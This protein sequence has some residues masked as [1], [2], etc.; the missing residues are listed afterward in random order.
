MFVDSTGPFIGN[1]DGKYFGLD[2]SEPLYIGG[3]PNT[4]EIS[5]EIA[6]YSGFVGCISRFKVDFAHKDITK[7]TLAKH[8]I[9]SCETCSEN[10]CNNEGV[11][12]ESLSP[13]GYYCICPAGYSG[14]TCNKLKGEACSS[15]KYWF[16]LFLNFLDNRS[17]RCLWNWTMC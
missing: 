2:L 15:C 1:A 8:G 11:C 9:T 13:E 5:P 14:A 16:L 12:Q 7:H 3:V 4:N 6:P 17:C 10:K